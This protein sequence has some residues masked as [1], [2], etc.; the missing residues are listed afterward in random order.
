[1]ASPQESITTVNGRRCTRSRARTAATSILTSAQPSVVTPPEI[2]SSTAPAQAPRIQSS[3]VEAPPLPPASS[4]PAVLSS[5]PLVEQPVAAPTTTSA[6]VS[7]PIGTISAVPILSTPPT[8]LANVAVSGP[9]VPASTGL[10]E[11]SVPVV[12]IV[13]SQVVEATPATPTI[14]AAISSDTIPIAVLPPAVS[15][16]SV[17]A[18]SFTAP[19]AINSAVFQTS[20]IV[21]QQQS[22]QVTTPSEPTSVEIPVAAQPEPTSSLVPS[23]PTGDAAAG[24]IGPENGGS[25]PEA[26]LTIPNGRDSNIGAIVGGVVGGVAG[27][28]LVCTLL[29]LCLRKRKT[30]QPKWVEKR[31]ER[32]NFVAKVK[33]IP[34]RVGILVEKLKGKIGP[35]KNPYQRHSQQDSIS[36]IYSTDQNGRRRSMSEPQ[37]AFAA[38]R[39]ARRSSSRRSERNRLR[40]KNGSVSSQSIMEER[41]RPI[42]DP[43]ADPEPSRTLFL[44]NPDALSPGV[45]TPQ[46]AITPA[47]PFSSPLDDSASAPGFSVLPPVLGHKRTISSASALSSHPSNFVFPTP[48]NAT[49]R[50][51]AGSASNG[52]APPPK[53][54]RRSSIAYP[55]FDATSTAASGNSDYSYF[56]GVGANRPVTGMFTPAL[57]TGRTVRQS[58]PFDLDRPEVLGFGSVTGRKEVRDTLMRQA[59]RG[60]RTSSFGNWHT[61]GDTPGQTQWSSWNTPARR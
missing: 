53:Q 40:K 22:S 25:D 56:S 9:L 10:V 16:S 52:Q 28:A 26:G 35:S 58:D 2:I 55:T 45:L 59:S 24:V 30:R 36:S 11:T 27:F 4:S 49:G 43:F 54:N 50:G 5:S 46:P 17:P 32:S 20:L 31:V 57:A 7:S 15:L 42:F 48:L 44:S 29:F 37:G 14:P 19:G 33:G 47:N 8:I 1:M 3:A 12:P 6:A 41:E 39:P 60:K 34:T 13:A 18:P 23:L 61:A 21:D 51:L 38:E